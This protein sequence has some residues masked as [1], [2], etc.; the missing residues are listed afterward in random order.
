VYG[1][2]GGDPVNFADPFGL[3]PDPL[4]LAVGTTKFL[5]SGIGQVILAAACS[6]GCVEHASGDLLQITGASL[7][8]PVGRLV[9]TGAGASGGGGLRPDSRAAGPHTTFRTSEKGSATNYETWTPQSNPRNPTPWESVVRVDKAGAAHYNKVTRETVPTP[10][11]H[12]PKT[13]GGVRPA[14][15]SEIPPQ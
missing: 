5:A 14:A 13:P 11:A 7:P 12:D 8:L 10:H 15:P 1:F 4:K 6:M 2:A 9:N 3:W